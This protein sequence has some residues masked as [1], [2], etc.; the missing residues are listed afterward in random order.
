ME[1]IT[2][3][4]AVGIEWEIKMKA[5]IKEIGVTGGMISRAEQ[6]AAPVENGLTLLS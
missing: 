1:I 5:R 2:P 4:N 6:E 3:T